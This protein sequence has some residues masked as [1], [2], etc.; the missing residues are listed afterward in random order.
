M[1]MHLSLLVFGF[2]FASAPPMSLSSDLIL[3]LL[4]PSPRLATR[5]SPCLSF[6]W[7]GSLD[8]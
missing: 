4:F 3:L 7:K 6:V 2:D 5:S 1:S 8:V